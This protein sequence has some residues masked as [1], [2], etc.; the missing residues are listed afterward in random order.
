MSATAPDIQRKA[1]EAVARQAERSAARAYADGP[2]PKGEGWAMSCGLMPRPVHTARLR[3]A[4]QL[5]AQAI[6]LYPAGFWMYQRALLL[7]DLGDFDGAVRSFESCAARGDYLTRAELQPMMAQCHM[8]Q[9]GQARAGTQAQQQAFMMGWL[10]QQMMQALGQR[11]PAQAAEMGQIWDAL[12]QMSAAQSDLGAGF[13]ASNEDDADDDAPS[14]PPLSDEQCT[15]VCELAEDFAWALVDG[16]YAK[17][18]AM[19]GAALQAE[20][21]VDALKKT[22]EDMVSGAQTP[23][24]RVQALT[25]F[26]DWPDMPPDTLAS[27]MVSIGSDDI[28]E[29]VHLIISQLDAGDGPLYITEL[30]WGS[31]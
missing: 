5:Y 10:K 26:N 19:L 14:R 30:E 13:D 31:L 15:R 21:R 4:E 3:E 23:I 22:Y 7:Q 29:A 8:L 16:H 12:A 11:S 25:P 27:V 1:A 20:I 2:L 6:A 17:A 28:Q 24:D 18:H 9:S